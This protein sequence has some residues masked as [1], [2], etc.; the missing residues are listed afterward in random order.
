MSSKAEALKIIQAIKASSPTSTASGW[1]ELGEFGEAIEIIA[2]DGSSVLFKID[3][4]RKNAGIP[5][6]YTIVVS[7][8]KL[9]DEFF[10]KD[11]LALQELT[12]EAILFYNQKVWKK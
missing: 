1:S 8:G 3:G 7:G 4:E 6:Y 12:Y 2:N 9:H 11:G 5:T 10:R